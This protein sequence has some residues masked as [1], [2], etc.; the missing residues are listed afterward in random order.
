VINNLASN[1]CKLRALSCLP[2]AMA[3]VLT[4]ST[5]R[6][7]SAGGKIS[8]RTTLVHPVDPLARYVTSAEL[9]AADTTVSDATSATYSARLSHKRLQQHEAKTSPPS[10][11]KD[12]VLV[13]RIEV[14]DTGV[15]IRA[16]DM[17]ENRLFSAY[18]QTEIGRHQVSM[19]SG[20]RGEG[21]TLI[22]FCSSARAGRE[23]VWD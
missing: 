18:V 10:P 3:Q 15:G 21:R 7:T 11:V 4:F 20:R 17:A 23:R 5:F 12:T 22:P 16:G 19:G 1:A 2:E 9:S 8:I 14:Q 6:S 13:A